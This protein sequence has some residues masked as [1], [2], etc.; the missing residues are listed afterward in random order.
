[1]SYT[2]KFAMDDT[3]FSEML[4]QFLGRESFMVRQLGLSWQVYTVLTES[5][6]Y[7]LQIWV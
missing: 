3:I 2:K 1:M 6:Y 5:T 4:T 7:L